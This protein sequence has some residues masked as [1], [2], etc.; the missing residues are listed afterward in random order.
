MSLAYYKESLQIRATL[1]GGG[2]ID[3]ATSLHGMMLAL[4]D[5]LCDTC[6]ALFTQCSIQ[7]EDN[8]EEDLF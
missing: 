8:V 4:V 3:V 2:H 1:Q 6:N 7:K 5:L